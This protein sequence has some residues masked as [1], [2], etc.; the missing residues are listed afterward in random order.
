M[1]VNNPGN[2]HE[3]VD[4]CRTNTL[5]ASAHQV[6]AYGFSFG[7]LGWHL[8]S[9]AEAVCDGPVVHKAPTVDAE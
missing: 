9:I 1:V 6:L 8:A 2:L 3:G 5:E 7:R 4:R